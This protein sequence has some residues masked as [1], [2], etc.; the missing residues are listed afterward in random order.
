MTIPIDLAIRAVRQQ[1]GFAQLL[2]AGIQGIRG[3]AAHAVLQQAEGLGVTI[4]QSP[5]NAN[6]ITGFQQFQQLL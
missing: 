6:R 2:D 4:A 3:N 5:Q 1:G